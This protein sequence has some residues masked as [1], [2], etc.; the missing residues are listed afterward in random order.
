MAR[1]QSVD[2]TNDKPLKSAYEVAMERL[3]KRDEETGV[4]QRPLNDEQKAAIA[5]I[6]IVYQAKIAELEVLHQSR[7]RKT[8]DPVERETAEAEVRRDRERLV[9]ERDEK[10]EKIRGGA[11]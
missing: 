1:L 10:I 4:L 8:L 3:R 11:R 5:D 7:L 2:M 9:S 6:R